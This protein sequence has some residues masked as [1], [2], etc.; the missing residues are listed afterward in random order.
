MATGAAAAIELG[1]FWAK[2][3]D[4][5]EMHPAVCHMLDVGHVTL[6][7]LER[8][9]ASGLR[10]RLAREL[11]ATEPDLCRMLAFLAACHDIGKVSSGFQSKREDHWKR[12]RARGLPSAAGDDSDH[13]RVTVSILK[14]HLVKRGCARDLALALSRA[15]GSHHGV[16]LQGNPFRTRNPAWAAAQAAHLAALEAAFQP[17]WAVLAPLRADR[18]SAAWMMSLAG[19]ASVCDWIG[20]ATELFPYAPSGTTD[21]TSY[22]A[23]SRNL[24][25][26][27]LRRVGMTDW[28]PHPSTLDFRAAFGF[29]PNDLQRVS[30]EAA[31]ITAGP[32]IIVIEAPMGLGKTEAALAVADDLLRRRH[33][34]GVYY[35]LP[36]QATSNQ[37]F[38]RMRSYVE[39]RYRGIGIDLHLVHGLSD[40][41]ENYQDLRLASVAGRD[42]ESVRASSWF[43]ARKRGLLSPFAVGTVD[44]ALLA[45]MSV[46]HMFVR[47]LGLAD[48]VVVLDE[49]HAYDTYT[50][51]LL[52]HLVAWLTALGSSVVVLSATLPAKRRRA[53]VEAS[54]GSEPPVLSASYPQVTLGGPGAPTS[55]V[56]VPPP[57][58]RRVEVV[59]IASAASDDLRP[60]AQAI[61]E[62]L[63]GGGCAAWVCNTVDRAQRAYQL[64]RQLLPDDCE[65]GLFHARFPTGQRIEIERAVL[66]AFGRTGHR[67]KRSVLVATQVVEQSLDLDFDLMVTDIAPIDLMLQRAGRLH[68]H[69]GRSRPAAVAEPRLM[70]VA[71]PIQ[72]EVPLLDPHKYVYEALVVLRTWL[73]L[74]GLTALT[75]PAEVPAL[76]E[77]VY[78]PDDDAS[79]DGPLRRSLIEARRAFERSQEEDELKALA[80]ALSPATDPSSLFKISHVVEDDETAPV[81]HTLKAQT[82]LGRPSA[83]IVCAREGRSGLELLDGRALD[84]RAAPSPSDVRS[85][86][87]S[88]LTLQRFEWVKRLWELEVPEA[89]RRTAALRDCRLVEFRD[90][91]HEAEGLRTELVLSEELG[92]LFRPR[93]EGDGR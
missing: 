56:K 63:A 41:N 16:F 48:K 37:M 19:L 72:D 24:A 71:P 47:M 31:A 46:R 73:L 82:R 88:S 23:R 22:S 38:A 52:D 76:V 44:Q 58:A 80:A 8:E 55:V 66:A 15:V 9:V 62:Q 74:R 25:D 1:L 86:R 13:G 60:A 33:L 17:N 28:S 87:C 81:H 91:V 12:L 20:S 78:S 50:S 68:R 77:A 21:L 39:G 10:A 54:G 83:T 53:L 14:E 69:A 65:H 45:A 70:W 67:P 75:L 49:V 4:G 29:A 79:L 18:L 90:G 6:A 89:W 5:A 61:A 42:D 84:L 40:L 2:A 51:E 27:A 36:T 26:L 85:I 64:I 43:T 34:T 35:A 93:T 32:G 11:D 7:F 92:L 59:S 57:A 3:A 30:I